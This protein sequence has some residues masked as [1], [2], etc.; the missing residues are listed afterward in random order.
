MGFE[1]VV[2]HYTAEILGNPHQAE[3]TNGTLFVSDMNMA[4]AD[5]FVSRLLVFIPGPI[6][7]SKVGNEI[8]FDFVAG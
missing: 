1:T 4:E 8:A 3:F 5:E 2:L 6:V 7:P